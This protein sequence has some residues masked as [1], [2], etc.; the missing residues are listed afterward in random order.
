MGATI[1]AAGKASRLHVSDLDPTHIERV[2]LIVAKTGEV[3]TYEDQTLIRVFLHEH[4][5]IELAWREKFEAYCGSG[6]GYRSVAVRLA[7]PPGSY[8]L[9]VQIENRL[10][11]KSL[12]HGGRFTAG[13]FETKWEA[14]D[15][16]SRLLVKHCGATYDSQADS[17]FF[18]EEVY[19]TERELVEGFLE[20][21]HEGEWFH[22]LPNVDSF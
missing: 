17:Y 15:F 2:C 7:E 16:A 12:P 20:S 9:L 13:P 3:I 14:V 1:L 22:I 21:L 6:H 4:S 19:A 11:N 18:N 10:L 5:T 8:S